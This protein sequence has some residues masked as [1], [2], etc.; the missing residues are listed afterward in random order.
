MGVS[1]V[2]GTFVGL[3]QE[4]RDSISSENEKRPSA[5]KTRGRIRLVRGEEGLKLSP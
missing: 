1:V 4:L 5:A 2:A 3:V